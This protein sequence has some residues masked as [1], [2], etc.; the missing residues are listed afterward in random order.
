MTEELDQL[1]AYCKKK[2]ICIIY[3][4]ILA[5][6]VARISPIMVYYFGNYQFNSRERLFVSS[7]LQWGKKTIYCNICCKNTSYNIKLIT[8]IS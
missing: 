8:V 2:K 6:V 4:K 1:T 5:A 3:N 7:K